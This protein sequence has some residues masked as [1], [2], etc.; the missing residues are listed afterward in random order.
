[1]EAAGSAIKTRTD[2]QVRRSARLQKA[3]DNNDEEPD[4]SKENVSVAS[5]RKRASSKESTQLQVS[6]Q[7]RTR[8][9]SSRKQRASLETREADDDGYPSR[10]DYDHM[11]GSPIQSTTPS[12]AGIN[13]TASPDLD[14][15]R[16]SDSKQLA[17]SIEN[18]KERSLKRKRQSTIPERSDSID[19]YSLIGIIK[20]HTKLVHRS[21]KA[22]VERCEAGQNGAL[23]ELLTTLFEIC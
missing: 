4:R 10:S 11:K 1:M 3:L 13:F 19:E 8:I 15:G 14:I 22:W 12:S 23:V 2:V 21:A 7:K 18:S 5:H 17:S 20:Y 6:Q 9:S 16:R